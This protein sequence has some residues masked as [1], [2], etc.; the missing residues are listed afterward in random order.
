MCGISVI[1]HK[2][3]E[4]WD[5]KTVIDK[6]VLSLSHRGPDGSATYFLDWEEEKIWIGHNLLAI[7]DAKE[8]SSQ[9]FLSE[10]SQCG[11][12]FNG[13]IFNFLELKKELTENG[14]EFKSNSDT[15]VLLY[16][17]RFK[18]RKGLRRLHGMFAFV[19]WDSS[20]QLLI[21]HRDGYGIKPLYYTR[22][23]QFLVFASEPSA[24]LASG[25]FQFPLDK[26]ASAYY[27]KYKFVPQNLSPWLGIKQVL[28]GEA[29][30]Y[31]ESKPMHFQVVAENEES[32]PTDL[33]NAIDQAFSKVIPRTE[34]IGIML[35]GG[36]DSSII[37]NWCLKNSIP[38]IPFSIRFTFE[39]ELNEDQKAVQYLSEL[40]KIKI[41]WVDVGMDDIR[42]IQNYPSAV[43]PLVAD[44][45]WLL[46]E[47]IAKAA[48]E[49]G[50]RILLSGAG[51][52]EWFAGYRRHWFFHLWQ[53]Y[54]IYL[55]DSLKRSI[56]KR[57]KPGILKWL[58]MPERGSS[59][60]VWDA[61]VSTRF[62]KIVDK[63]QRISLP[64]AHNECSI[65][66]QALIWDQKHYLV[67]DVLTI[68]DLATM[69]H[70]IEG[71]FPFLYADLTAFASSIPVEQLLANGRKGILK[72][73]VESWAGKKFANRK[74]QGFGI[75]LAQFFSSNEGREWRKESVLEVEQKLQGYLKPNEWEEWKREANLRPQDFV[76]EWLSICWL[77]NWLKNQ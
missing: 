21:I 15:E 14:F 43:N 24:I 36:I 61:A 53:T 35:S 76:Q 26:S 71:R 4:P 25:L 1:I 47:K 73:H 34:P 64:T 3:P 66:D 31:W 60:D 17:L 70:G 59:A 22:N 13:Q 45:A 38:V 20:K 68:T 23:R 72:K 10:D 16:W 29:I 44:S 7:S 27:L 8:K 6:M 56:F 58:D 67:Q 75:P 50:I 19:Y 28:P 63:I 62:S 33:E 39:N 77:A 42:Q 69:A 46:T 41:E 55:P 18:G 5:G 52:D 57:F 40:F 12:V 32:D 54:K 37:L 11:I 2:S 65:V 9:P 74:K 51:A 48:K 30:E 49:K